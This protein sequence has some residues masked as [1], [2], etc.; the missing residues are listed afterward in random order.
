MYCHLCET[1]IITTKMI[2]DLNTPIWQLTVGEFMELQ[3]KIIPTKEVE[4][5]KPNTED[6]Y[7]HGYNGLAKLFGCSETTAGTILS[8]G[9]IDKAVSQVGRAIVID[10]PL[11]LKLTKRRQ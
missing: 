10:A 1:L 5:I 4:V 11:A 9:V 2:K 3:E 7:V 6:R 8:S